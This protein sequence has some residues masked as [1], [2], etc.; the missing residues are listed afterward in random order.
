M[1]SRTF[2]YI[3]FYKEPPKT[4]LSQIWFNTVYPSDFGRG[5]YNV[6]V[7]LKT[8]WKMPSPDK[9]QHCLLIR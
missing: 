4:Y 8:T 9:D 5:D 6:C 7:N 3:F 1:K 2:G